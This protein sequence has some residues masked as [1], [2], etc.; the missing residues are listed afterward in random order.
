MP[1]QPSSREILRAFADSAGDAHELAQSLARRNL[2]KKLPQLL[3]SPT[4][5]AEL[6]QGYV[7]RHPDLVESRRS[8]PSFEA[9]QDLNDTG[10]VLAIILFALEE[11]APTTE[12]ETVK[13]ALRN[14]IE[15]QRES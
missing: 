6:V 10:F 15:Q 1:L 7:R 4:I 5:Q 14:S 12:L 13:N 2:I 9:Y 8:D 11:L 3:S